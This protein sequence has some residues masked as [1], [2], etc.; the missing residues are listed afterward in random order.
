MARKLGLSTLAEGVER[1]DT[2][3]RLA[4]LGCDVAGF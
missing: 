4:R 2:R 1:A 3:D